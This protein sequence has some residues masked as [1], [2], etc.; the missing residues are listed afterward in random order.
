MV[1]NNGQFKP[2]KDPKRNTKG[3]GPGAQAK[4]LSVLCAVF[5]K[6]KNLKAFKEGL[7]SECDTNPTL[8]LRTYFY[9]LPED[10]TS[11]DAVGFAAMSP[12][13]AAESMDLATSP[14]EK[15]AN[16]K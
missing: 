10:R 7:Q 4:V 3:R 15:E 6:A 5:T 12:S 13:Q 11:S 16:V 9:L 8:F 2:G 14:P 1:V